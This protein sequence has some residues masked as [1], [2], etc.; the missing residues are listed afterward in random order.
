MTEGR[1][2]HTGLNMQSI[3]IINDVAEEIRHVG[4]LAQAVEEFL[5]TTDTDSDAFRIM[6]DKVTDK[7]YQYALQ[8]Q[9]K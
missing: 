3:E 7:R 2:W 1:Q 5:N 8:F 9:D 6:R 4:V